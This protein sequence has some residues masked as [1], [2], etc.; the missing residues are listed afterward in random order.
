MS[1]NARL[2]ALTAIL[3]V[4]ERAPPE[5][6]VLQ[7]QTILKGLADLR[8]MTPED[9]SEDNCVRRGLNADLVRFARSEEKHSRWPMLVMVLECFED[10]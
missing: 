3:E 8:G 1:H 7:V 9:L 5:S 10:E 4:A 6:Q 2:A